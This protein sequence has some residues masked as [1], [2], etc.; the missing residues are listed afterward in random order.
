LRL[1]F[2]GSAIRAPML[3][4]PA[5][6]GSFTCGRFETGRGRLAAWSVSPT[7]PYRN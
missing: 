7:I 6:P 3:G 5:R 2:T 4:N 1:E